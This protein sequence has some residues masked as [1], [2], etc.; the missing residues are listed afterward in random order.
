MV[1]TDPAKARAALQQLADPS[2]FGAE[3]GPANVAREHPAYDPDTY[4]RGPAWPPLNY[5]FQQAYKR[6]GMEQESTALAQLTAKG[7]TTSGWAEYWNADNGR[8][9]GA[10]PQTWAGLAI[11]MQQ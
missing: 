5:L 11:A 2:R 4:W 6:Q 1:T 3:F 10:V 9:L 7:A 8:G